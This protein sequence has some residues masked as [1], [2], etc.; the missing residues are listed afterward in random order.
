MRPAGFCCA[1]FESLILLA[2][3]RKQAQPVVAFRSNGAT[4]AKCKNT[5]EEN[6]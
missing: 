2:R 6:A 5:V 1:L 3:L 4:K